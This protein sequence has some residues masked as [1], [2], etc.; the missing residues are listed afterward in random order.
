M[1]IAA[2]QM[3]QQM[4]QMGPGAGAAMFAPGT[5]PDKQF[6]AEAENLAV[7]TQEY[8]LAGVEERLLNSVKV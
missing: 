1:K 4:G 8:T 6:Q 3:Q 2:S 7:Y 5:D